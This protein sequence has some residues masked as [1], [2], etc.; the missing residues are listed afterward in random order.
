[1]KSDEKVIAAVLSLIPTK[2]IAQRSRVVMV[3]DRFQAL[4]AA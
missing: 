2:T 3:D 1:M 4:M